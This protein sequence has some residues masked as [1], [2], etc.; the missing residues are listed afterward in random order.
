[1]WGWFKD[2]P[3]QLVGVFSNIYWPISSISAGRSSQGMSAGIQSIWNT[4]V[5][6]INSIIGQLGPHPLLAASRLAIQ[7]DDRTRSGGGGRACPR[8][9]EGNAWPA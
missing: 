8:Y 6:W 4:L 3:G 1:M 5:G 2:L 7:D 9:A